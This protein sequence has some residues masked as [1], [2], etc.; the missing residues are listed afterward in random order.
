LTGTPPNN[1]GVYTRVVAQDSVTVGADTGSGAIFTIPQDTTVSWARFSI[2]NGTTCNNLLFK[3]MITTDLN[4]KYADYVPYTGDSGRLNEDVAEMKSDLSAFVI[5]RNLTAPNV[6]L[7]AGGSST[8]T[9]S[10]EQIDGYFPIALSK[11]GS[12]SAQVTFAGI[13]LT[14][15]NVVATLINTDKSNSRTATPIY[16]IVYA[17]NL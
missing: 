11:F 10:V 12:G 7:S 8:S 13:D 14:T 2:D 4:A 6:N 9:I 3:P 16:R 17:K 1:G 15:T 5:T